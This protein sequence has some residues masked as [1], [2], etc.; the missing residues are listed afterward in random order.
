MTRRRGSLFLS[1]PLA[2]SLSPLG[3]VVAPFVFYFY[4]DDVQ[5]KSTDDET[6][7]EANNGADW[8]E[9]PI[10]FAVFTRTLSYTRCRSDCFSR[11]THVLDQIVVYEKLFYC[12]F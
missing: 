7:N 11:T 1:L 6:F 3:F 9:F 5:I 10:V 2:M 12:R 8:L 4:V